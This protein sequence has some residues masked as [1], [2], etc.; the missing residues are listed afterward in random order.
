VYYNLIN[1][2]QAWVA[3][4][5]MGMGFALSM[6]HGSALLLALGLLWWRDH[7]TNLSLRPVAARKAA[8]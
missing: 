4:G 8:P 5:K 6:T 2:S 3:S 7:G 1:L